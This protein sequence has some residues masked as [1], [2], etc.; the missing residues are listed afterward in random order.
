MAKKLRSA[1]AAE[2][3]IKAA[4]AKEA[5]TAEELEAAGQQ[6]LIEKEETQEQKPK[7]KAPIKKEQKQETAP[8]EQQKEKEETATPEQK[9]KEEKAEEKK[10]IGQPKKYDEPTK[11]VSFSLPVSVIEDLKILAGLKK[12]NQTQLI[13]SM[14]KNE[15]KAEQDRIAI[16]KELLINRD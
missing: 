3:F 6:R 12:T 15:L 14:I 9:E 16:Y 5:P 4:E 11:H 13:L 8:K 1:S 2:Q 10:A 7:K